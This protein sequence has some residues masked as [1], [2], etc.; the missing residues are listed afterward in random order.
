MALTTYQQ[1]QD[2]IR[3][4][5][6]DRSDLSGVIPDWIAMC[7]ARL[8]NDLRV[9]QMETSSSITLTSGSGSLPSDYLAFRRVLTQDSPARD[10]QLAEPGWSADSYPNAAAGL[11]DFFTIEGSTIKTF[12]P[13][14]ANVTL[15][16][17]QKIPA[18]AANTS[19]NWLTARSPAAYIYGSLLEGAPFLD[20]DSRAQTWGLLYRDAIDGLRKA[21]T[22]GRYGRVSMRIRGCTP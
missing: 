10:L 20:D 5:L 18:L 21:D 11:A 2:S 3:R 1:I 15:Y 14:S 8:N 17:Y 12:P 4:Y 6:W 13:S 16:Y 22:A 9:S 7:E 19:G